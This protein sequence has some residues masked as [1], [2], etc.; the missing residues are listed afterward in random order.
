MSVYNSEKFLNEGIQ[1]IL[2]QTFKNFE[3]IIIDDYSTDNS[4]RIIRK[5]IKNDKRIILLKNKKNLGRAKTRNKGLKIANGN[6]VAILDSDD[7]ALPERLEIQYKYL[8]KN[9]EIFLVGGKAIL[10]N[11][12][13]DKI[14]TFHPILDERK[15]IEKLKQ[16]NSICHSTIMFRNKNNFFYREKFPYSQD[17]DL[18][19]RLLSKGKRLINIPDTLIKYRINPDA[20]SWV[21][22]AKQRLFAE[23][24]REFYF[25]RSQYGKDD[26][27]KFS[28]NQILN[29]DTRKR[30]D[31]IILESEIKTN[32]RL[33]NLK[34]TRKFCKKYFARYG[35]LNKYFFYYILS[36]TG[37]KFTALSK[38]MLS[39]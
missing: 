8:E 27:D 14:S 18:Y 38:R 30:H 11:E 24:A 36:F 22:N 26:Y 17:Y 34:G 35:F 3:F 28:L 15:L 1:S 37:K 5:Y 19:L 16:K 7:I 12:E 9:P 13:G 21:N 20:V 39:Y 31:S 6:Y 10:I 23:K 32:F 4:L 29:I 25:Q 33:N 2:S